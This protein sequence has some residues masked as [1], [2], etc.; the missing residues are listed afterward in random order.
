MTG[1]CLSCLL[2]WWM[3]IY[4]HHK[5][6]S[7]TD[8]IFNQSKG[9]VNQ[10]WLGTPA[11]NPSNQAALAWGRCH[12]TPSQKPEPHEQNSVRVL[13]HSMSSVLVGELFRVSLVVYLIVNKLCCLSRSDNSLSHV[14]SVKKP[15]S[16]FGNSWWRNGICPN[17]AVSKLFEVMPSTF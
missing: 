5:T 10:H 4:L 1:C 12:T 2:G 17:K 7:D 11:D 9:A 6:S 15:L 16:R 13:A 8:T 14:M 3:I